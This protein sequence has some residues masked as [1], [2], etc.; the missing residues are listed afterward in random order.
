MVRSESLKGPSA[1][2]SG[3]SENTFGFFSTDGMVSLVTVH[4]GIIRFF[5]FRLFAS[6]LGGATVAEVEGPVVAA[7]WGGPPPLGALVS[8][9]SRAGTRSP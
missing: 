1:L 9:A 4:L 3:D 8:Y 7:S 5:F 6:V 2:E